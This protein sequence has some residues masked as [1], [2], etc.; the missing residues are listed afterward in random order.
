M[1]TAKNCEHGLKT[2]LCRE[3][4]NAY[5]KIYYRKGKGKDRKPIG[6]VAETC[7]HGVTPKKS[8]KICYEA[9]QKAYQE[10][11][12]LKGKKYTN[13]NSEFPNY[14]IQTDALRH[15][16]LKE[17]H[18]GIITQYLINNRVRNG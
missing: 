7:E 5:A 16:F 13:K 10:K 6:R 11:I 2:Y 14:E 17:Y 3:C 15:R 1:R 18:P 12:K 4:R 9:Y 8:C